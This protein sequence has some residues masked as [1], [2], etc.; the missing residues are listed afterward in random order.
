MD[1][2]IEILIFLVTLVLAKAIIGAFVKNKKKEREFAKEREVARQRLNQ[3][4]E[5]SLKTYERDLI[6]DNLK[7]HPDYDDGYR[8]WIAEIPNTVCSGSY[9]YTAEPPCNRFLT[10][11]YTNLK[12]EKITL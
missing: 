8:E 1:N 5:P 3:A 12:D 4:D 2:S 6:F 11:E 10:G 9:Y 7:D